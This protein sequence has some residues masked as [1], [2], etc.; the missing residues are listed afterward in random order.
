MNSFLQDN[1]YVLTMLKFFVSFI[2]GFLIGMERQR[3]N[4][5]AGART[6]L[7]IS[8]SATALMILATE[9]FNETNSG[10]ITRIAAAAIQGMGFLGAGVILHNVKED[11]VRVEGITTAAIMWATT[12]V[13]L[14]IGFGKFFIGMLLTIVML[15]ISNIDTRKRSK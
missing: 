15:I 5:N 11:Q 14:C 3:H 6:H 10:D 4:K 1:Y 8:L 7:T 2:C 12:V 13:G 9:C